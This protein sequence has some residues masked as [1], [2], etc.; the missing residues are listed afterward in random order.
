M[1][2]RKRISVIAKKV[3]FA[4]HSWLI[5]GNMKICVRDRTS[6]QLVKTEERNR[7]GENEI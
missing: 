7:G 5:N 3:E 6:E 2:A 4:G 1:I